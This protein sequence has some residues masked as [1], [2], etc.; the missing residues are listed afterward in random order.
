MHSKKDRIRTK[1]RK[2]TQHFGTKQDSSVCSKEKKPRCQDGQ[3]P[4]KAAC[5]QYASAAGFQEATDELGHALETWSDTSVKYW[6]SVGR[7]SQVP[8]SGKF[9]TFREE[10]SSMVLSLPKREGVGA[11]CQTLSERV[12]RLSGSA[13]QKGHECSRRT[14][15]KMVGPALK[16]GAGPAHKWC[17]KEGA[18]TEP[19]LIIRDSQ[20]KFTADPQNVTEFYP[21]EWKREWGGE[22]TIGFNK[23]IS[24][25]RALREKV[26][27]KL[28]VHGLAILICGPKM[29]A[30]LASLSRPRRRSA[31]TSTHS[32]ISPSSLTAPWTLWA[33]SSDNVWSRWQYQPSHVCSCWSCWA[34]KRREQNNRHL[35]HHVSPHHA[36]G[37]STQQSMGCQVCW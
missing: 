23:E 2:P 5:S 20:G 7:K 35:T 14:T 24:S 22:D 15:Q 11:H 1:L 36:F 17:G 32:K 6:M 19:P 29:F 33:R 31:S 13:L 30:K 4:A 25:I 12:R 3:E 18:L 10:S 28:L 34:R 26:S 21:H 27:K 9:A 37:L 16:G 8:L